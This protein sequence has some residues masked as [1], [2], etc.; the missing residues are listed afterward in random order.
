MGLQRNTTLLQ[1]L[2]VGLSASARKSNKPCYVLRKGGSGLRVTTAAKHT[3]R[4]FS[5]K[6]KRKQTND[7]LFENPKHLGFATGA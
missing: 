1:A 5:L 3:P 4:L 7:E 2:L 6:R